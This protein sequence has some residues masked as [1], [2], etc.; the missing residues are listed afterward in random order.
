LTVLTGLL[1]LEFAGKKSGDK[2]VI[3]S[4]FSSRET[5]VDAVLSLMFPL[6]PGLPRL[7]VVSKGKVTPH[8]SRKNVNI[9]EHPWRKVGY[10]EDRDEWKS[11]VF[12]YTEKQLKLNTQ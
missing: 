9:C 8:H 6:D 3:I 11:E 7:R 10:K 5:H 1:L 2:H 4:S 12:K